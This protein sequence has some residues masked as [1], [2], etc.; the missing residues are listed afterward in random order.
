MSFNA[1]LQYKLKRVGDHHESKH[2]SKGKHKDIVLGILGKK[3]VLS[4]YPGI[5]VVSDYRLSDYIVDYIV[6]DFIVDPALYQSVD[7]AL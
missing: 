7:P 3:T 6:S 2:T 4:L 1:F 5:Y